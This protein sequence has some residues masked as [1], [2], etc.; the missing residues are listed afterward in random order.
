MIL[1]SIGEM[2][3]YFLKE[4]EEEWEVKREKARF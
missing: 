1:I 2:L 4:Q 3:R